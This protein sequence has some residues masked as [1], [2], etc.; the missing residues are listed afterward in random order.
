M[1]KLTIELM[2]QVAADRCGKCLST[3]YVNNKAHLTWQC[4]FGHTWDASANNVKNLGSWCPHCQINVGEE[5]TRAA[6]EE[7]LPGKDFNRTSS[8]SW[9]GGLQLDGYNEDLRLA[10]E[11]QG[12]QHY[13]EVP[14]FHRK[15][16][17]F[18][19]QLERDQRKQDLCTE[20]KVTLLLIPYTVGGK[21]IRAFVR[22]ELEELG[23]A[24]AP[25]AVSDAE[26]YDRVRAQAPKNERAFAKVLEVIQRKG[27]VCLSTQYVGYRVPL[28]IRCQFDH[29][30]SAT[31]EAIC[32]PDSRGPRFCTV[33][34]GT[35][36]RAEDELKT[37]VEGC[38][39]EYLGV[40]SRRTNDGRARR[41][42]QVRCPAAH[43]YWVD[44]SNFSP[45]DGV[46][47]KGCGACDQEAKATVRRE[48]SLAWMRK[49]HIWPTEEYKNNQTH[50]TWHCA[51]GHEFVASLS[52]IQQKAWHCTECGLADYTLLNRVEL[53]T[54]WRQEYKQTTQLRFRCIDCDHAYSASTMNIGRRTLVCIRCSTTR[55]DK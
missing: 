16:G 45:K 51:M 39:F 54:P 30:F 26:F 34:G 50:Y 20:N 38:G 4:A 36:R 6:I 23:Y 35:A 3:T 48:P 47:E 40:E 27:G 2:Q 28:Q 32:Q 14:H 29:V 24:I 52:S 9:T 8:E 17:S 46:P 1:S 43:E 21:N 44:W 22:R 18:E 31:P 25:T 13:K 11:F 53:L 15:K 42:I 19:A 5:L 12:V 33:C 7:A 37:L 55:S 41:Y 49:H 10:F